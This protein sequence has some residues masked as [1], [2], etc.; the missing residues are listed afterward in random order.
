MRPN[1][2]PLRDRKRGN[3]TIAPSLV[4]VKS[5]EEEDVMLPSDGQQCGR[6]SNSAFLSNAERHLSHLCPA[7]RQHVLDLLD[8]FPT[9]FGDVPSRTHVVEHDIDVGGA[10]PIKQHAYRCPLEKSVAMEER[11]CL[12]GGTW[13]CPA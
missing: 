3:I 11:S 13:S 1:R 6:L 2:K 4:C 7:H 5:V 12:F 8:V 10:S 9:L